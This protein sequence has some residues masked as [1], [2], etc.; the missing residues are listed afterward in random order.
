[1]GGAE[2]GVKADFFSASLQLRLS[3]PLST[4]AGKGKQKRKK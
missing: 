3:V 2:G 4:Q 1:V